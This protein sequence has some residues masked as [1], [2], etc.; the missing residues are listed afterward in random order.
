MAL[1]I[2]GSNGLEHPKVQEV[3]HIAKEIVDQNKPLTTERL[4]NTAKNR[5]N[6]T[7]RGLLSIIQ[8]LFDKKILVEGCRYTKESLLL[9]PYRKK[10]Y[11]FIQNNLGA[12]FSLIKKGAL[13]GKDNKGSPGQLI[14]HLEK[15]LKFK[16]IKRLK[17]GKFML[18]LP[19]DIDDNVGQ[20]YFIL[21]D[22]LNKKIIDLF[23]ENRQLKKVNSY[24]LLDTP[25][26]LIYYHLNNLIEYGILTPSEQDPEVL[27]LH[28]HQE[29]LIKEILNKI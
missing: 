15:L 12:H 14:W 3:I 7:R 23:I 11:N 28:P 20:I 29:E 10:I 6:L 21:R 4:Y 22:E 24:K 16:Y 17:V 18:F 26:E 8:F 13:S 19:I 1:A 9:N 2:I 27:I 5:L 25:R